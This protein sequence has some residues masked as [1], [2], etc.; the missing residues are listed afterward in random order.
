MEC[1]SGGKWL[2]TCSDCA[3]VDAEGGGGVRL[4]G[5]SKVVNMAQMTMTRAFC[6]QGTMRM[7]L[8]Q[9]RQRAAGCDAL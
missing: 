7:S 8:S 5:V 3:F 4:V 9:N 1:A 6:G 2:V